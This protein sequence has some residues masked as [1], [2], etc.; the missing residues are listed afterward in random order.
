MRRRRHLVLCPLYFA[1]ATLSWHSASYLSLVTYRSMSTVVDTAIKPPS[2]LSFFILPHQG[3]AG[4]SHAFSQMLSS[5]VGKNARSVFPGAMLKLS[6][7]MHRASIVN[8]MYLVTG[9]YIACTVTLLCAKRC[10]ARIHH[11]TVSRGTD[12]PP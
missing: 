12:L 3:L 9:A 8:A 5:V 7:H 4:C 11:V 1:T 6:R 10:S 2:H